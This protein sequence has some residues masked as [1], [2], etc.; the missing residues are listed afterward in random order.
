MKSRKEKGYVADLSIQSELVFRGRSGGHQ[1]VN[2]CK[3]RVV[4]GEM[5]HE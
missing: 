2:K 1:E 3:E 4:S 5:S